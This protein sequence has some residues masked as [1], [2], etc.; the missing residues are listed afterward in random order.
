MTANAREVTRAPPSWSDSHAA[1]RPGERA[2]ERADEREASIGDRR[3]T[4]FLITS[5]SAKEKPMNE[6]NVPM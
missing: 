4:A 5:G 2:D 1:E 6:P 3:G